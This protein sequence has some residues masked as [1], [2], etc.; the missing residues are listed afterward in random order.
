MPDNLIP[1]YN[2][3]TCSV[4]KGRAAGIV[5]LDFIRT[6][7]AVSHSL[8]LDKWARHRP[9][10]WSVRR[11]GRLTGYAPGLVI[12]GSYSGWQPL[13]SGVPQ[14][15]ILGPMLLNINDLGSGTESMTTLNWVAR[16]THQK[17]EP[18]YTEIWTA[19]KS[20]RARTV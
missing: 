1:F 12:S 19:W 15:S 4:K 20:G 6:L 9:D 16:W 17:G 11:A 8:L 5:Y 3:V 10:G 7:D 14:A 18:S 13:T 2:K